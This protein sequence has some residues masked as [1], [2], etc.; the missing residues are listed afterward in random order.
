MPCK[1][2]SLKTVLDAYD[3]VI[4]VEGECVICVVTIAALVL[5]P[6]ASH[7][8]KKEI[9]RKIKKNATEFLTQY[10]YL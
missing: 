4:H 10:H 1:V 8:Q 7:P 3:V 5:R 6:H 9:A 2:H